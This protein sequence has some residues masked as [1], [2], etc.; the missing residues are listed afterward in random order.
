MLF[1]DSVLGLISK[2]ATWKKQGL[3]NALIYFLVTKIAKRKFK[4]QI[5]SADHCCTGVHFHYLFRKVKE[6]QNLFT[7]V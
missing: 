6:T 3:Q 4:I 7:L 1:S 2:V 5:T